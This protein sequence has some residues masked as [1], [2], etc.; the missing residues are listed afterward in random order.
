MSPTGS[1]IRVIGNEIVQTFYS[2]TK[3]PISSSRELTAEETKEIL[4]YKPEDLTLDKLSRLLGSK[5]ENGKALPPRFKPEDI[6][7]IPAGSYEG[8]KSSLK[9]TIGRYLFNLILFKGSG[10]D[11]V[12]PYVNEDATGDVFKSIESKISKALLVGDI[13]TETIEK[14]INVRDWL[15]LELHAIITISFRYYPFYNL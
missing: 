9:T 7:T 6:M 3:H 8:V 10:T 4:S 14:Y 12:V 1:L 11:K 13:S 5:D 15:G 2:L